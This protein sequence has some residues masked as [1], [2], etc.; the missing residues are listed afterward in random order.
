MQRLS[1]LSASQLDSIPAE[2]ANAWTH[3]FGWGLSMVGAVVLMRTAVSSGDALTTLGC[4]IYAASLVSLYA[5]S[6]LSHSV[7]QPERKQLFAMLDQICIF[8]LIAGSY[9]PFALSHLRTGLGWSLLAAMWTLSLV[10]IVVRI[11]SGNRPVPY[12]WYLP[13][14]FLPVVTLEPVL[15][16]TGPMGLFYVVFGGLAYLVGLWFF[17]NDH[18]HPYYHA[19]W[20]CWVIV[21][22][23][24]HFLF[25]YQ[26]VAA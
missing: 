3:G 11:R 4:A 1:S 14:A 17:V 22:S 12:A 21:G 6:T 25:H 20:H 19:A 2:T 23:G 13:Q 26:F 5:A 10:G 24:M 15:A 7:E 8:L 16:A 9:T 18:K